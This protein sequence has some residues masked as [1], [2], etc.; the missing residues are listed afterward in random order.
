MCSAYINTYHFLASIS[1]MLRVHKDKHS[2]Y[3]KTWVNIYC[4]DS[5]AHIIYLKLTD[6]LLDTYLILT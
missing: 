1:L 3:N 5:A 6:Y 4:S 2:I